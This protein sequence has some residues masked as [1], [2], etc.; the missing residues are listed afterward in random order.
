MEERRREQEILE[1]YVDGNRIQL[2]QL[3]FVETP[4]RKLFLTWISKAMVQTDRRVKTE[5]G[6]DVIVHLHEGKKTMLA[7]DDG[8]LE[9]PDVTFEFVGSG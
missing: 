5:F 9:L 8:E 4:V 2:S 7:S 3:T 1:R 6:Q